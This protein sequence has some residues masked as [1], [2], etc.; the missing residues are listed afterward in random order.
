MTKNGDYEGSSGLINLASYILLSSPEL[1]HISKRLTR[2]SA[3]STAHSSPTLTHTVPL[4]MSHEHE[5]EPHDDE[6]HLEEEDI[7][8]VVEDEGDEPMDDDD[9][10]NDKYDGEIIIGA[11][12]PGEEEEMMRDMENQVGQEDNSWGASGESARRGGGAWRFVHFRRIHGT[13]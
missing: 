13:L 1:S 7:I 3:A 11:P 8:E 4:A 2:I 10:D 6:D 9:D 12:M 5:H